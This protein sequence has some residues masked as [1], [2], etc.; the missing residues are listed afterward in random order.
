ME[1]RCAKWRKQIESEEDVME[2][3]P[4][5][6]EIQKAIEELRRICSKPEDR[7][8]YIAEER[9]LTDYL[10]D[11]HGN[12]LVGREEERYT[13]LRTM[14]E[15]GLSEQTIAQY[16]NIPLNEVERILTGNVE[17]ILKSE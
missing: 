1:R 11:I 12:F 9:A 8:I 4:S 14:H 6:P 3:K 17:R 10:T 5:F 16:T 2:M 7:E 15:N 13:I